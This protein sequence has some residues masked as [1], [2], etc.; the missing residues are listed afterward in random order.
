MPIWSHLIFPFIYKK[1][2]LIIL[3][4]FLSHLLI[5][6]VNLLNPSTHTTN[7]KNGKLQ[8][9]RSTVETSTRPNSAYH[10]LYISS[11]NLFNPF[12][13]FVYTTKIKNSTEIGGTETLTRPNS[14]CHRFYNC[15]LSPPNLFNVSLRRLPTCNEG[16]KPR[17]AKRR[18]IRN[19]SIVER[20]V[21]GAESGPM[22]PFQEAGRIIN[23]R[24]TLISRKH[25]QRQ[26]RRRCLVAIW[27]RV[28]CSLGRHRTFALR[29]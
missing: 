4:N 23:S 26:R 3:L 8:R 21:G 1:N 24:G 28:P 2:I 25:G 9:N 18:M 15:P 6:L 5:C 14:A 20:N 17:T 19:R 12:D 16:Q 22:L 7:I 10:R 29:C 27:Q 11:P 13:T